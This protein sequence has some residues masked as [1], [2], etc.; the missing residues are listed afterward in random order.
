MRVQV[1]LL[2][3]ALSTATAQRAGIEAD[4]PDYLYV[5]LNA[6]RV[7]YDFEAPG[8]EAPGWL[9]RYRGAASPFDRILPA[10][11]QGWRTCL[12]LNDP[13][14]GRLRG[15]PVD[16]G[17]SPRATCYFAPT[18]VRIETF[19]VDYRDTGK[20][21]CRDARLASDAD[22]LVFSNRPWEAYLGYTRRPPR[23]VRAHVLPL[24]YRDPDTLCAAGKGVVDRPSRYDKTPRT[25]PRN[26]RLAGSADHPRRR[27]RLAFFTDQEGI[28]VLPMLYYLELNLRQ[29]GDPGPG[30]FVFGIRYLVRP[31]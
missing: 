13:P 29:L 9:A 28:Q 23:G 5:E 3:A 11:R 24:V 26:R 30:S 22:L 31:R 7:V 8:A 10:D 27:L 17:G 20:P 12:G 14:R 2:L 18:R 6:S 16:P 15:T 1:L 21:T 4:Y 25:L 19:R